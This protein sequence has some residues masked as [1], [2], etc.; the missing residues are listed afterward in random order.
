MLEVVAMYALL[1][2]SAA[3]ISPPLLQP[4]NRCQLKCSI[5]Y[6]FG[7]SVVVPTVVCMVRSQLNGESHK[8]QTV[9][10]ARTC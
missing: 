2:S 1:H 9:H 7:Q 8:S 3:W 4:R 6:A 5:G 10:L